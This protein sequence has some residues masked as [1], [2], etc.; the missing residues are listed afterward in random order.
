[1]NYILMAIPVFFVLIML[2]LAW[3]TYK[4]QDVYRLNDAVNSLAMGIMSRITQILY[5]AV[6]FSFYVYFYEDFA[7]FEWQ[8]NVWTWL[9]AFVLYDFSYYWV[10]RIGHTMNISWASHVIHH[11]SEEYNLSTALRQ[12]SVPNVIGWVFYIP[13]AFMGFPPEILVAVGSLNLLYQFWVHTQAI[14]QM[15]RWYEFIFVTP[16]NH[17]VH[18]AKNKMYVDKNFGGVFLWDRLFGTFQP[19][20]KEEKVIFGISTQLASWN[21]VW[22]NLH[23]LAALC[24]DAWR[25]KSWKDKFTLWF[26]RTGYRPADVEAKYPVVKSNQVVDKYDTPLTLSAKLYVIVQLTVISLGIFV[27]M[28][29]IEN[30]VMHQHFSIGLTL[31]FAL[32]SLGKVQEGN[33]NALLTELMKYGLLMINLVWLTTTPEWLSLTT[34][35]IGVLSLIWIYSIQ[36]HNNEMQ[37]V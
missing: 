4:K 25:T 37:T 28:H 1:M 19:E 9:A 15:P 5:A 12:T 21:P 33:D 18:H 3:T 35:S 14:D 27:M 31:A 16:S 11:S 36:K 24:Q 6:P 26:R 34:L 8:S 23:F 29:N 32:Y 17:R 20:L 22:G 7:L 2:E 10:H 13:L 30:L